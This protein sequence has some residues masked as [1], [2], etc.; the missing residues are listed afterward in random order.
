MLTLAEVSVA[1]ADAIPAV[2]ETSDVLA[3]APGPQGVLEI[4]RQ[5]PLGGKF[6][7]IPLNRERPILLGQ[8]DS[9]M[10]ASIPAS[11]L[12]GRNLGVF[13]NSATG[14]SWM[15]GLIAEGLHHEEYQVLLIDPEGDFRGLRVL[16]RFVSVNG[17]RATLPPPSAVVSLLDAGGVSLVLDLSQYPISLRSHYLAELIRALRPVREQKFRPHWIVLDE[18]QEFLFEG[19]EVT[20]LLRPLLETGGWAFVSYRPDRLSE[21]VLTSLHHCLLTRLTDSQIGDCLRTHCAV[22][23]LQNTTFDQIPMGSALLCSGEIVR[24]RP[25]IRRVPHVRHLYKYL[26][27]PLPPGKRF[28]FRTEKGHLGIEAASLYELSRLIPT[29][30]LESLEYHDRREDFVKWADWT[31]GDGGLAPRL[32]KVAN[33]HYQGE[34]L[35]E[36]LNQVV[37][38]HYEEL[39]QLK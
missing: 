19:S 35:R 27:V 37:S 22:C 25:A 31:L 6:L 28:S 34:E 15:V 3:T 12:A 2:I 20:A 18:A 32:R 7:D 26:D 17:D 30:P 8:T 14:K 5:Y 1:V 9:G 21:S 10:V 16:P 13:G 33:R 23:G 36:A 38:T 4:L 29:L 24:M 39:R 11:W